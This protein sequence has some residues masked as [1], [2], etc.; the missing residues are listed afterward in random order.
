MGDH[1]HFGSP[2]VVLVADRSPN[3]LELDNNETSEN[4]GVFQAEK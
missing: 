4:A 1:F 2:Q 3:R